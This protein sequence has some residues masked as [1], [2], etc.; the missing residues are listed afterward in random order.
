MAMCMKVSMHRAPADA[1][2][3]GLGD[4]RNG[5]VW[6]GIACKGRSN[7]TT[8]S[9]VTQCQVGFTRMHGMLIG[10]STILMLTSAEP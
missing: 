6:E 10:M 3:Q 7:M 2:P 8:S 9:V 4:V 1:P 5:W